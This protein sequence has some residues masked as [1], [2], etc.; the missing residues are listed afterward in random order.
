MILWGGITIVL[1]ILSFLFLPD[2]PTSR[3]FRLSPAER[4]I[5]EERIRENVV[6]RNKEFKLSHIKEA[7]TESRHTAILYWLC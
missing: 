5:A 6:V 3:S 4:A 2:K 1:G 7:V